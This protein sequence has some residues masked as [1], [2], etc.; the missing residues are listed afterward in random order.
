MPRDPASRARSRFSITISPGSRQPC[1]VTDSSIPAL[2]VASC[3]E[4]RAADA[5]V[6]VCLRGWVNRRRDHGGLI[7]IDIRDRDGLTQLVFDPSDNLD[8]AAFA[9]AERLRAEFV[10][11][12]NGTV[13]RDRQ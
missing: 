13:R 6:F 9:T 1:V 7:F 3:G 2:R 4:L 12:V 11:R 5:G 8:A 10:I